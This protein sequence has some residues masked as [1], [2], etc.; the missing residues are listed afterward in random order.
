MIFSASGGILKGF[1]GDFS[2]VYNSSS[3]PFPTECLDELTD[4]K[5]NYTYEGLINNELNCEVYHDFSK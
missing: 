2:G 5:F 1:F 3:S 4:P